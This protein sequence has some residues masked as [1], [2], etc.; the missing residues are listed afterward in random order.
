MLASPPVHAVRERAGRSGLAAAAGAG[1]LA[2]SALFFSRRLRDRSARLD[3][4]PR[5]RCSRPCSRPRRCSGSRPAPRLDAP[6]A[7]FAGCLLALAVWIGASTLWSLSPDR[8]WGYTN[9]TLVYAAF[10]LVGL[11]LAAR[12]P[13]PAPR[14]A[15]AAAALVA[16]V[17]GWALLAKCVPALYS[18]YGRVAR[19]RAPVG[20]WNELALLGAVAVPLA[21]LARRAAARARPACARPGRV[22]LYAAVARHAAHLLARRD[23]RSPCSRPR[24]GRCSSATGSRPSSPP[25]SPAAPARR[26]SRRALAARDHE[27]R[28]SRGA[29]A[30]ARRLALRARPCSRGAALVAALAVR[31][32]PAPR[33]GGRSRPR[34]AARSS[35]RPRS[36]RSP[37]LVAAI[38]VAGGAFAGRIWRDFANPATSQISSELGAH[39]P[40]S[41]R[42][43]AGAGGSRSGTPSR[44]HPLLG[45]GAGTFQLT[46]LRLPPEL[47]RHDRPSRTTRRSSS[48]ASSA[49]SGSCSSSARSA[50]AGV[51]IVA[52]PPAGRPG[53]ERAA[54]TALGIGLA[55]FALHHVVDMDWNFLAACGPLLLVAGLLLGRPAGRRPARPARAGR[56]SPLPPR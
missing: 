31:R 6:A 42:A 49:S 37:S 25:R 44:R 20:Y 13:R 12:L 22:L 27:R 55:A 38:A 41:A 52:R 50:A 32:S 24:P 29:F 1:A 15:D 48:S 33:R 5:A 28:R 51:G 30:C 23:R 26:S 43:T 17:L 18:D 45:T 19:L 2:F 40:A 36:A 4:R 54:V 39:A 34:A 16:L 21:L 56:S 11:M 10:A 7:V 3:R 47:A 53:A 46:D 8:S 35:G 14:G 9:R